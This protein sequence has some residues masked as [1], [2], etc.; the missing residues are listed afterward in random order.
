[1]NRTKFCSLSLIVALCLCPRIAL[2]AAGTASGTIKGTITIAGKPT[3]DVVVSVEGVSQEQVKAQLAAAK[4]KKAIMDQRNMKFVPFVLAVVVGSTVEFP[5][6]DT[7]WHNVYS[8]GGV[9]DFDLGLY[10][11][12][13]TRSVSFD[14]PGVARI[15]CNAHPNMEAFIV[16]KEHPFFS[17]ADKGGNYRLDSVPLG[18]YRIQVRH[19]QLG[20]A[21]AGGELVRAGEVLDINFDLKK[22]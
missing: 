8:K 1:M 20:T 17:S 9:K 7:S 4:A 12:G 21:E 16:V 13:K 5:N 10:P 15:L 14:K 18:K 19:P 22:K 2:A 11:P 3:Q 6:N